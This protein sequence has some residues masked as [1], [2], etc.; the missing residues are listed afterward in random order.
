MSS[1]HVSRV[2][3]NSRSNNLKQHVDEKHL[4]L[5]PFLCTAEGCNEAF[6][7]KYELNAHH[8]SFHT[9]LPSLRSLR[10]KRDGSV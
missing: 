9:D 5:R 7:R 2:V 4:G 6:K 8:Q 3:V 1:L 10:T